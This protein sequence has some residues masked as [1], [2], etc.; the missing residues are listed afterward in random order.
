MPAAAPWLSP[1]GERGGGVTGRAQSPVAAR[2][3]WWAVGAGGGGGA[4]AWWSDFVPARAVQRRVAGG[5][6]AGMW[7]RDEQRHRKPMSA[8]AAIMATTTHGQRAE[9]A[10]GRLLSRRSQ[11]LRSAATIRAAGDVLGFRSRGLRIC[12]GLARLVTGRLSPPPATAAAGCRKPRSMPVSLDGFRSVY[13]VPWSCD[14]ARSCLPT[15]SNC[16]HST[17]VA[18]PPASCLRARRILH[19]CHGKPYPTGQD[20][21]AWATVLLVN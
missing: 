10:N 12:V 17:R 18:F 8:T 7:P 9:R 19:W 11:S 20:R 6:F 2:I 14:S 21:E 16:L 1:V 13:Q 5:E 3:R 15:L 4:P